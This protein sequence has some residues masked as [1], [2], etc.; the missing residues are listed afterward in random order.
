MIPAGNDLYTIIHNGEKS[1][2]HTYKNVIPSLPHSGNTIAFY[3]PLLNIVYRK[4]IYFVT[5][6]KFLRTKKAIILPNITDNFIL[7]NKR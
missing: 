4:M 6:K 7:F 2:I 3:S 1:M 5:N